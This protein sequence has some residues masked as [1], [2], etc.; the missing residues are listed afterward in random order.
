MIQPLPE[1]DY[2]ASGSRHEDNEK[3]IFGTGHRNCCATP[4]ET[5]PTLRPST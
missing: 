5:F 4:P 3:E 2:R 1:I